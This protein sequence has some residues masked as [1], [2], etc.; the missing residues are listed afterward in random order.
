MKKE[1]EEGE[2]LPTGY[3]ISWYR[4][5]C[6]LAV[7]YPVPLNIIIGKIRQFYIY[8]RKGTKWENDRERTIAHKAHQRGYYIGYATQTKNLDE[9]MK[10]EYARKLKSSGTLEEFIMKLITDPDRSDIN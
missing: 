6:R 8:L 7:C 9:A 1:I 2:M 5:D 10:Q 3:G 4:Y